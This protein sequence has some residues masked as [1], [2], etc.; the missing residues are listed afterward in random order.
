MTLSN[1][2]VEPCDHHALVDGRMRLYLSA[3]EDNYIE[4]APEEIAT[5][6]QVPD[7]P[8]A[9]RKPRHRRAAIAHTS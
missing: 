7:P 6:E 2:F 1:G 3:G 8:V 9:V 5:F 4:F